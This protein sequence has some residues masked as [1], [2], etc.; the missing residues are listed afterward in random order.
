MYH[1]LSMF[2][3]GIG[4]DIHVLKPLLDI[5]GGQHPNVDP[6]HQRVFEGPLCPP[7]FTIVHTSFL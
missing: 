1:S 5:V 6:A 4:I 2:M 7:M 3:I